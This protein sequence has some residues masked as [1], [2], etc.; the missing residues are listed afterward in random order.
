MRHTHIVTLG[1]AVALGLVARRA[2]PVPAPQGPFGPISLEVTPARYTGRCPVR[3]RFTG[4][5]AVSTHPMAF[6]YQFER[7]DGAKSQVRVVRVPNNGPATYRVNEQWQLGAAGQHMQVWE[8]LKVASGVT[9][10]ETNPMS[11]DI[12]CR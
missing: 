10:V 5:I 7:S 2:E 12:T 9:R 3:L 11:V 4:T 8:K 1:L 6:N